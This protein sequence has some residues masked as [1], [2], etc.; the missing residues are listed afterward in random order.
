MRQDVKSAQEEGLTDGG[1]DGEGGDV[2]VVPQEKVLMVDRGT[3][4]HHPD[5]GGVVHDLLLRG[6]EEVL[7]RVGLAL[8]PVDE[9]QDESSVGELRGPVH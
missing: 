4:V 9:V 5:P 3:L 2:V 7:R 1:V 8:V 6:V